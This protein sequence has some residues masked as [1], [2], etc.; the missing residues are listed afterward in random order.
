MQIHFS[1]H[2]LQ[3]MLHVRLAVLTYRKIQLQVNVMYV[4]LHF[5][6]RIRINLLSIIQ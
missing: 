5:G 6:K 3:E 1:L 2:T 4:I